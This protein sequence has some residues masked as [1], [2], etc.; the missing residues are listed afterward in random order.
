MDTDQ[1]SDFSRGLASLIGKPTDLRPFV[2]EGSPLSC[3]AFLVGINPASEMS[4]DFWDFWSDSYG[5]D[6]RKWFDRYIVE[7]GN[8]LLKP[9]RKR[10]NQISNT[11]RVIE[12]ILEEARPIR[13][14]E[15]NIYAKAS[16][17]ASDL[18]DRSRSTEPF[19]YLLQQ[20]APKLVIAH[21]KPATQYLQ[22]LSLQCG[23]WCE[24]HFSR[25]WSEEN[26]R[27]LGLRIRKRVLVM[28]C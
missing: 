15:T 28:R 3:E 27:R 11:R 24:D 4:I 6:K 18:D 21:G 23:L 2:C 8:R 25:C 16:E 20:V 22:D 12:W 5:F 9:G 19:F 1:L 13:C 26:A 10:R 17:Q 14:L 7:R